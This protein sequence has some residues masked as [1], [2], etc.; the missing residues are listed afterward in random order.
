MADIQPVSRDAL[1]V[2]ACCGREYSV[3]DAID[4]AL[5]R[6]ELKSIWKEFLC[7]ISAEERAKES[8]LEPDDDAI[9]EMAE[10][11]RYEHDL[12]TA[13]ETERWLHGRGL[14]LEDFSGYFARR[15]WRTSLEEK[16]SLTD[17]NLVS[18]TDELRQLFATEL[19]FAGELDHLTEQLTWRLAALCA[20][21]QEDVDRQQ[22]A[23][24]RQRFLD[25][26]EIKASKLSH[27]LD[28]IGRDAQWMEEMLAT[29]VAYRHD[30]EKVLTA[31]ARKKQLVMLRIPMTRFEAEMIEVESLDAAREA[32]L[33][34]RQDGMSMEEVAVEAR[35]PYRR[36]TFRHEEVPPDWQQRFWSVGAGDLLEPLPRS[37]GFELYRIAKKSEPDLNDAIVRERIDQRLL[38]RHFSALASEHVQQRLQAASAE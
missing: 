14:T 11:F 9:S 29:E 10:S 8:D 23:A 5:F 12:I 38:E 6:G 28:Q 36:I 30:H 15:Y 25:R 33:C 20:N 26:N 32:L 4:A 24:E 27:W 3:R 34:I 7:N 19:I 17:Q 22:I 37:D 35:Y 1:S 31:E 21:K 16:V 13:E 18:A 2:C